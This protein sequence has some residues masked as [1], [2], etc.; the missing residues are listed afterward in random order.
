[1]PRVVYQGLSHE[2]GSQSVLDC[3]TARGHAIPNS[4]KAGLCQSCLMRATRGAVPPEA[5]HGLNSSLA[6]RQFFLACQ[7][8]PP[9]DIEVA[10]A[11]DSLD[12]FAAQVGAIVPLTRDIA[13]IRLQLPENYRYRAGQFLRLFRDE[14]TWRNYSLASVPGLDSQLEMHVQRVGSGLVSGWLLDRVRPGDTLTI[15]EALGDCFYS[16]P[17]ATQKLLLLGTGSGLAPLQGIVRD[18]LASGHRGRIELYHGGRTAAGL[19][20]EQELRALA[21]LHDNFRYHGCVAESGRDS[22]ARTG[23][24]LELAL[25]DHPDLTG[26]RVYLCGHPAMVDA[27]RMQT[28]LAGASGSEIFADPFFSPKAPKQ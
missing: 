20:R 1:M 12:R 27:A 26:W 18:A 3:L 13:A 9:G 14:H 21:R 16:C 11:E 17:D 10:L 25:S 19:Y 5:Q 22:D 24:A 7:C 4:C 23:T 15:S 2:A 8:F 28:F 6:A